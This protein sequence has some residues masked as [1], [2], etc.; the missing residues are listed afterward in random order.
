M[1]TINPGSDKKGSE[2]NAFWNAMAV[3]DILARIEKPETWYD[4][5]WKV[6]CESW[7]DVFEKLAPGKKLLEYGCGSAKTSQYMARSGYD[8]TM[9]DYSPAGLA[10]AKKAFDSLTLKGHFILGDISRLCFDDDA[11]DIVFSGGVLEFFNDVQTPMCEIVRVLKPGGLFALTVVP[12]KFSIQTIAD[13][14]I[15][16]VQAVKNLARKRWKEAFRIF[17]SVE[18]IVSK[19]NLQD[20]IRYC[21]AM[22]LTDIVARCTSPFPNLSIGSQG[23]RLYGKLL[24]HLSGTWRKFNES[25]RYLTEVLGI[26][27][28]IYAIKGKNE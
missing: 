23:G 20:Y 6:G 28:T 25:P 5:V 14:E 4:Y 27:Y 18:P 3:E 11:F 2:W 13:M 10:T 15:T 17:H 9:L 8:C 22:G 12:N 24:K 1:T 19:A 21:E 26:T 16:I 7:Y